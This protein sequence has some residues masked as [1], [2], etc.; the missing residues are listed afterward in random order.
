MQCFFESTKRFCFSWSS[1]LDLTNI[2]VIQLWRNRSIVRRFGED[3]NIE[4]VPIRFVNWSLTFISWFLKIIR[5]FLIFFVNNGIYH[6]S[7]PQ[8]VFLWL[9]S[10]LHSDF[11]L[12]F[13][14]FFHQILLNFSH[15]QQDIIT[16][17]S[18]KSNRLIKAYQEFLSLWTWRLIA[19]VFY[20][21]W[22]GYFQ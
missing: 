11:H 7:F 19:A 8:Y 13:F 4:M 2:L 6:F 3:N 5:S 9:F 18:I 16:S 15:F 14:Q 17:V 12:S 21:T 20:R 1:F 22:I 10:E